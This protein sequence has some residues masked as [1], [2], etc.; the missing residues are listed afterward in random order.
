MPKC[1][2]CGSEDAETLDWLES[3]LVESNKRNI[4]QQLALEKAESEIHEARTNPAYWMKFNTIESTNPLLALS[5]QLEKAEK[6]LREIAEH[7]HCV[8]G[9]RSTGFCNCLELTP[10]INS[11]TAKGH[12]CAAAVAQKYFE[13]KK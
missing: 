2:K 4:D 7:E 12:R 10:D 1:P 11:G 13:D 8:S 6:A 3:K 9:C 5:N